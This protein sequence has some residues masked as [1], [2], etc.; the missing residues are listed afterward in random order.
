MPDQVR[1]W[2]RPVGEMAFEH[3]R[4]PTLIGQSRMGKVIAAAAA[5][6]ALAPL[7][8]LAATPGAAQAAP[9]V[10][11]LERAH[12]TLVAH[13]AALRGIGD[14]SVRCRLGGPSVRENVERATD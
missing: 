3:Y 9:V 8:V 10:A 14:S 11:A 4:L 6:M 5:A 13:G 7:L 2:E 1:V 12:P